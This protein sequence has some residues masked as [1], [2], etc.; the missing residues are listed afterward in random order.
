MLESYVNIFS[1]F[2]SFCW[3]VIFVYDVSLVYFKEFKEII[4][5]IDE[6]GMVNNM[7][8]FV[9][10]NYVGKYFIDKDFDFVNFLKE[11]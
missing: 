4:E 6:Y 1:I 2:F 11:F 10:L 7:Y 5:I 3:F 8:F 9:I